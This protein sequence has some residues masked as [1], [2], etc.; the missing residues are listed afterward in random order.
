MDVERRAAK[1]NQ[2]QNPEEKRNCKFCCGY[3]APY[4]K[5]DEFVDK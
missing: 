2:N 3:E 4:W 1:Q 5:F